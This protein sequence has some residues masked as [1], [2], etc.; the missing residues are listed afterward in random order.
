[1]TDITAESWRRVMT[2]NVDARLL[3]TQALI[4]QL[5]DGGRVRFIGSMRATQPRKGSAAYCT[6]MARNNFV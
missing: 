5:C 4:P 2:T 1:M 3:L 6:A